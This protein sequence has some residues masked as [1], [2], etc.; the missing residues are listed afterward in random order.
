MSEVVLAGV[1]DEHAVPLRAAPGED[2]IELGLLEQP[3]RSVEVE[4]THL[5]DRFAMVRP[6]AD[7]IDAGL[8]WGSS[9]FARDALAVRRSA[10]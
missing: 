10:G 9:F 3:S 5:A 2:A 6:I 8:T 7:G 1:K 4:V